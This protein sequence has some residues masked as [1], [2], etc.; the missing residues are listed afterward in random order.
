MNR[1]QSF[2][3]VLLAIFVYAPDQYAQAG[4][5]S[6][7][8]VLKNPSFEGVP[9]IGSDGGPAPN[10]W[11]DCGMTG[12]TAPDIHPSPDPEDPFF[13]VSTQAEHGRT[14][15]GMVV[16]DNN[17]NE[18]VAQRLRRPMEEGKCYSFSMSLARSDTYLSQ[19]K[20]TLL[21]AEFV[22]PVIIRI[23]GGNGFCSKLELLDES[24][25]ISNVEWKKYNFRLE[26]DRNYNFI[27]IEAY[28]RNTPFE[29][30]GNVLV[31]N[32]SSI[33]LVPCKEPPLPAVTKVD[34][35]LAV[36]EKDPI[37]K[38]KE[39]EPVNV[40]PKKEDS[41]DIGSP[42]STPQPPK[43]KEIITELNDKV[44]TGQEIK[45]DKLYF[46]ADSS[47][48]REVVKPMLDELYDFLRENGKVVVEIGGHTN[49]RCEDAF[50]NSLS[51]KRAKAVADYL[52][53]KGIEKDRVQYKGYGK[54]KPKYPNNTRTNMRRN[55]RVELKILDAG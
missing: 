47:R 13:N 46:E 15:L 8:I 18:A 40:K 11:Y 19:S 55:Q 34:E 53:A 4:D 38:P 6:V 31:D 24:P 26:P 21:P 7:P 25:R 33:E 49:N 37:K 17:T 9:R 48:I 28:Y 1:I 5:Q 27:L 44:V 30:N 42:S 36:A 45:L 22:E 2:I 35:P 51:E 10:G 20:R 23:Y 52:V 50:C 16:R 3:L 32:L 41:K 29:Y 43:E 54:T 14:Y 39:K 12:E